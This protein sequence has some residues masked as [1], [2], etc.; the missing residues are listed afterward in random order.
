M[1]KS[2]ADKAQSIELKGIV[3]CFRSKSRLLFLS[4]TVRARFLNRL[5]SWNNNIFLLLRLWRVR[6]ILFGITLWC[7]FEVGHIRISSVRISVFLS[8]LPLACFFLILLSTI[9]CVQL[10]VSQV[11]VYY[12]LEK[13]VIKNEGLP[14][15]ILNEYKYFMRGRMRN[16]WI[17]CCPTR[18]SLWRKGVREQRLKGNT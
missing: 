2:Q 13:F 6:N 11:I 16:N 9:E 17:C 4:P 10:Q 12:F 5:T 1:G 14:K 7:Y 18:P 3:H 15:Q 8:L